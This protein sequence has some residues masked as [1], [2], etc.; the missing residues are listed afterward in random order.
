[1]ILNH[2]SG[3]V[4]LTSLVSETR[5]RGLELFARRAQQFIASAGPVV[6]ANKAAQ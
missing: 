3:R 1:M 5:D 4:Q 2:A 6:P